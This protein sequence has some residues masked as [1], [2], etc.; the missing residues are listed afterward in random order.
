MGYSVLKSRNM[1]PKLQHENSFMGSM[2]R[3]D[4]QFMQRDGY[5]FEIQE[6]GPMGSSLWCDSNHSTPRQSVSVA[7]TLALYRS[8][9]GY[10]LVKSAIYGM[11]GGLLM[12]SIP[13]KSNPTPEP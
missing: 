6:I 11:I 5:H 12:Q 2:L 7:S 13:S 9:I 4:F 8:G 3:F 1:L 10:Q